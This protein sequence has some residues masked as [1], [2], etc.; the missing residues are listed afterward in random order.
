MGVWRSAG[1]TLLSIPTNYRRAYIHTED[2]ARSDQILFSSPLSSYS[3]HFFFFYEQTYVCVFRLNS[4]REARI[5]NYEFTRIRKVEEGKSVCCVDDC[6]SWVTESC[7][8][9]RG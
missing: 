1:L 4:L 8:L 3:Y 6:L 9:R 7:T 5:C 2:S